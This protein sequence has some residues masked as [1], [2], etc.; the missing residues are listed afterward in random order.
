[1]LLYYAFKFS[2]AIKTLTACVISKIHSEQLIIKPINPHGFITMLTVTLM[3]L[4]LL[5]DILPV[6]FEVVFEMSRPR[7]RPAAALKRTAEDLPGG[8]AAGPR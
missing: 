7:E 5:R 1:M 6:C 3:L 4:L 8:G 2:F